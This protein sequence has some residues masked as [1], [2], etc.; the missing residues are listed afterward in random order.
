MAARQAE[1]AK[2]KAEKLKRQEAAALNAAAL[3]AAKR[4][5]A[6]GGRDKVA[7][8]REIE[9]ECGS[10]S[11]S[12]SLALERGTIDESPG[13]EAECRSEEAAEARDQDVESDGKGQE[14]HGQA[15]QAPDPPDQPPSP[16]V[17]AAEEQTD[18]MPSPAR[19]A[20]PT[21]FSPRRL[22]V[23]QT[24][25]R[26]PLLPLS[27][28]LLSHVAHNGSSPFRGGVGTAACYSYSSPAD[29][30]MVRLK[31]GGGSGGG[32]GDDDEEEQDENVP[33]Q[34]A[35]PF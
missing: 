13:E 15:V 23:P 32:S 12:G 34:T 27:S 6:R 20:S 33:L 17:Q 14:P 5:K 1:V 2:M 9:R 31:L 4:L 30:L 10:A 26:N 29:K 21:R 11:Q 24:P 3:H 22:E 18:T 8:G 7:K 28:P 16:T 19:S 35:V 25:K